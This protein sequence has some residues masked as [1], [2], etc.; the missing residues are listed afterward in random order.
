MNNSWWHRGG[1]KDD[2]RTCCAMEVTSFSF[3]QAASTAQTTYLLLCTP[4]CSLK[5]CNC[6][7]WTGV[8]SVGSQRCSSS[9]EQWGD[10]GRLGHLGKRKHSASPAS[11]Q[12]V[13][14]LHSEDRLSGT[15]G[16]YVAAASCRGSTGFHW[17]ASTTRGKAV[18]RSHSPTAV[19]LRPPY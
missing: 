19:G 12:Q 16:H 2:F 8:A 9:P 6:L 13:L 18:S 5:W 14:V 11:C 3:S 15:S 10:L 7:Y 4:Q 17:V 1:D